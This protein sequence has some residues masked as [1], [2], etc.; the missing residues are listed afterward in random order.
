V[1]PSLS[2]EVPINIALRKE[3]A[4]TRAV[5][6]AQ[7]LPVVV[8][9]RPTP[10]EISGCFFERQQME[11]RLL[12]GRGDWTCLRREQVLQQSFPDGYQGV[13][14][15]QPLRRRQ[16][17]DQ[18]LDRRDQGDRPGPGA[19]PDSRSRFGSTARSEWVSRRAGEIAH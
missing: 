9:P 15:F 6:K 7:G 3:D 4:R 2:G 8:E 16:L 10:P 17:W 11:V 12:R 1:S 5:T 18:L 13:V 19:G 14:D